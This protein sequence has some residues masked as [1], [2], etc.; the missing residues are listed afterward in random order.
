MGDFH[1]IFMGFSW[2]FMEFS[3]DFERILWKFIG[4]HG[5]SRAILEDFTNKTYGLVN[6]PTSQRSWIHG[7]YVYSWV[8]IYI[9]RTQ[10]TWRG[11]HFASEYESLQVTSSHFI[12]LLFLC[13]RDAEI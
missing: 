7:E 1:G 4:F 11:A 3:G 2:D 10:K 8:T 6:W 9:Y 12:H 5:I 13:G